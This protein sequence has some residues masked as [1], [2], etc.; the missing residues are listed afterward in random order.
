[1]SLGR[2]KCSERQRLRQQ[3]RE[4]EEDVS[5]GLGMCGRGSKLTEETPVSVEVLQEERDASG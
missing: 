1:M 3:G 2:R 4:L 5:K